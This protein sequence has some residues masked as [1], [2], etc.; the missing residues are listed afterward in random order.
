MRFV[1]D[2]RFVLL[3]HFVHDLFHSLLVSVFVGPFCHC[4]LFLLIALAPLQCYWFFFRFRF[5]L[6]FRTSLAEI[7]EF[8]AYALKNIYATHKKSKQIQQYASFIIKL[9]FEQYCRGNFFLRYALLWKNSCTLTLPLAGWFFLSVVV[10]FDC[11]CC[12]LVVC[13]SFFLFFSPLAMEHC[14]G[15]VSD[16]IVMLERPKQ[17]YSSSLQCGIHGIPNMTNTRVNYSREEEKGTQ[18]VLV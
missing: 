11:H 12:R 3:P 7:I 1:F 16:R 10:F 15:H 5:Q 8:C 13:A 6:H 9:L 14:S 17:C 4:I 18:N 2:K